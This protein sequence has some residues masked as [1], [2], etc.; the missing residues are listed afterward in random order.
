MA[1]I[2]TFGSFTA[3]RLGIYAAQASMNVVGNNISNIN[4]KGYTRQRTDLVSLH[5]AG[6]PRYATGYNTDI[7][8]GVLVDSV[9]Q[10]R[11]PFMDIRYRDQNSN[12]GAFEARVEG[13][14]QLSHILDEVGDGDGEFGILEAQF[15]DL[16][17]QLQ[18]LSKNAG[19]DV[20]D[21]NVR[22][23]AES[24][25]KLFNS[26][27]KALVAAHDTLT[28]NLKGDVK[29]VNSILNQIRDLNVEIREAGI[30]GEKALELR[31]TRNVLIDELSSYMKI[32][33]RYTM[34][35][36]GDYNE[37]EKLIISIADTGTP[38]IEL[39]NG[40]Y[41]TQISMPEKTLARNPLYDPTDI[42]G[43]R[44]LDKDGNPTDLEREANRNADGTLVENPNYSKDAIV[45]HKYVVSYDADGN[46]EATTDDPEQA[47]EVDNAVTGS[48]ENRFWMQLEPLISDRG[49]Y[50][51]DENGNDIDEVV[52]LGDNTL[53][54]SLQTMRELLT[55]EG[56]FASA[57]D[58]K[59]DP[60]ANIKR[61][62][63][64]YQHALDALAQQFAKTMNGANTDPLKDK[65]GNPVLD[66]DGNQ[67]L[68]SVFLGYE[69]EIGPD[70]NE[71][72]RMSDDCDLVSVP[73]GS[74]AEKLV[75]ELADKTGLSVDEAKKL[76][77]R[78]DLTNV[79]GL[80]ADL[81][82]EIKALQAD[83]LKNRGHGVEKTGG[84]VLFSNKGDNDDPTGITAANISIAKKWSTG[85]VRILNTRV[86]DGLDHSTD[87]DN[88]RHM[89]TLMETKID[90]MPKDIVPDA[91]SDTKYFNGTFQAMLS[92]FNHLLATDQ[93]D[94]TIQYNS[95]S[96]KALSLDND[97]S[98]VSGV[99]LNEEATNMMQYQKSY[100]AACQLL[101]TLDSMLDKLI[102]GTIR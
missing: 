86:N 40:I 44:Y 60:N 54:G 91:E 83:H 30:H 65:D 57:E 50:M 5:S 13:L 35:P 73:A 33:V 31:D 59:F 10:L 72:Y 3:A 70:G 69:T 25:V 100:S 27:S 36:V 6:S 26:Y 97:R 11:D 8:Y 48:T 78:T 66:Q 9:S 46:V 22:S 71:Y 14:K 63:P 7:G 56:E 102:N 42:T 17:Q 88:I 81:Q 38:P 101:T 16:M 98:S 89:I 74:D 52:D 51:K 15:N 58:L 4:T 80:G 41:G 95:F 94:S 23:S 45:G 43:M 47:L 24:I 28:D 32:D 19:D 99:D 68:G 20:M 29:E 37:V 82:V 87:S 12:V 96:T 75:Q 77:V 34:E 18:N 84:G 21:T 64:Y 67:V 79:Q 85:E 55:E 53:Y 92:N 62:I 61:G 76:L 2:G 49:R 90:Y 39:I 1:V 93:R